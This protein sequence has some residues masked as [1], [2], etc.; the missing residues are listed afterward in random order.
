M[1]V[2]ILDRS[3]NFVRLTKGS[4]VEYIKQE[5]KTSADTYISS[6]IM[7]NKEVTKIILREHG[8]QVPAGSTF[9]TI[10]AA[11]AQYAQFAGRNIACPSPLTSEKAW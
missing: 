6:L 9:Q 11:D 8:I 3:D 10:E 4:K 7:E 2:E 5:T 1:E